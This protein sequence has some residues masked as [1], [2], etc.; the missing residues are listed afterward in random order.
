VLAA[1]TRAQCSAVRSL[2]W[3]AL[4]VDARASCPWQASTSQ[5][6]ALQVADFS[7]DNASGRC[8]LS[9]GLGSRMDCVRS[10]GADVRADKPLQ[11]RLHS[12]WC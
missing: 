12:R 6:G 9:Q 2:R 3:G 10:L 4:V 11:V 5:R 8:N 7:G 1:Q